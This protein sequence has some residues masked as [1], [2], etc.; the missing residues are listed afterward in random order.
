MKCS[1][2]RAFTLVEL[3]VVIGIIAVLISI[4]LPALSR[5][6]DQA[7]RVKCLSNMRQLYLASMEFA[8]RNKD[9]IPIGYT[10][11]YRQMNYMIWNV[12]VTPGSDGSRYQVLGALWNAGIVKSPELFFCPI[13]NDDSNSYNTQLNAW[14]PGS[15]LPNGTI[16]NTR[17]S[18]S[19]RP[20][21]SWGFNTYPTGGMAKLSKIKMKALFAD[22]VSDRDDIL[23]SHKLGSNVIYSDGSGVWVPLKVFNDNL[24]QCD[25]VFSNSYDNYIYYKN[26]NGVLT[27]VWADL[28]AQTHITLSQNLPGP[29]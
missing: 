1:K 20:E 14:P 7:S 3:L 6:R 12:G 8:S 22:C 18:Y 5:A 2:D 19:T 27:G 21:I 24:K 29:R 9:Q 10:N 23:Q 26:T 25:P 17:A 16:S 4:L 28:D 11:G 15:A 13:R